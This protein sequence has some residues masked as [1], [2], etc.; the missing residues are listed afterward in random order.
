MYQFLSF[1]GALGDFPYFDWLNHLFSALHLTTILN[2]TIVES[3]T[4]SQSLP[5][6]KAEVV[7]ALARFLDKY[8][9]RCINE[10]KLEEKTLHDDPGATPP[11]TPPHGPP[12]AV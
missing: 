7:Q 8:G 2:A 10:L 11:A 6:A 9:F 3:V 1:L 12:M 4:L 5:Q